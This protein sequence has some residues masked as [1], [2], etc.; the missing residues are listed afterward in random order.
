[1]YGLFMQWLKVLKFTNTG[2]FKNVTNYCTELN[3]NLN[4]KITWGYK[5]YILYVVCVEYKICNR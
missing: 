3:G 5:I 2:P 4:N 1:V